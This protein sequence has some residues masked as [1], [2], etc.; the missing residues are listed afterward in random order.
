MNEKA[1]IEQDKTR[2]DLI[3]KLN[4][5]GRCLVPRC[6]GFGKTT[7]LSKM[8][9]SYRKVLYLYPTEVIKSSVDEFLHKNNCFVAEDGVLEKTFNIEFMTYSKLARLL[10]HNV[11]SG[12]NLI[13]AD[14]C[15]RIG[16]EKTSDML[17]VIL[18]KNPTAHFVGLSA[19]PERMDNFDVAKEFFNNIEVYKYTLSDAIREGIVQKPNYVFASYKDSD[20]S[21]EYLETGLLTDEKVPRVEF[22]SK[23]AVT[24]L[25]EVVKLGCST[26]NDTSTMKF[27]IFHGTLDKLQKDSVL[28]NEAFTE[29]FPTH[30]I[31][32][33]E[34]SSRNAETKN[35]EQLKELK[36]TPNS[37]ILI[38]CIDMLNMG[39]HINSLTGI[40][41]MRST[42]SNIIFSQQL[43][44]VISSGD[45]CSKLVIDIADNVQ[46]RA[47][48]RMSDRDCLTKLLRRRESLW[49]KL[50]SIVVN[51]KE[52]GLTRKYLESCLDEVEYKISLLNTR[53]SRYD[54]ED[55]YNSSNYTSVLTPKDV[56][57]IGGFADIS[58]VITKVDLEP[59]LA[60]C[61][62]AFISWCMTKATREGKNVTIGSDNS[63]RQ[64]IKENKLSVE[65]FLEL[66]YNLESGKPLSDVPLKPFAQSANVSVGCILEYVFGSMLGGIN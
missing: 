48:Y 26:I 34:I 9:P 51:S 1:R 44:R 11:H 57:V 12:Y 56:T 66:E 38:H 17:N 13:V 24:N 60:K 59:M 53:C 19:T 36:C 40:I 18:E 42:K 22:I 7:M 32:N 41:M 31:K 6:T 3:E 49:E 47:W 63:I 14:E 45:F 52:E 64:F 61:K 20:V 43:G 25:A 37:I 21:S 39:Y 5:Y 55:S 29:V 27:I 15:H 2:K 50:Q 30:N 4:Q 46:R 35:V 28:V 33:V 58:S 10:Y 65:S 54:S 16:A 62:R 23:S 8:I